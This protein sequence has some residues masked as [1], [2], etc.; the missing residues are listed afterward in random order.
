MRMAQITV[1]YR[2]A[3]TQAIGLSSEQLEVATVSE[4]L[5]HIKSTQGKIVYKQAKAM[6][7]VVNGVS[8]L[9]KRV[10]ATALF[11]GDVVSFLPLAAGG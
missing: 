2:G 7:I 8:I 4:V 3:L 9:Q 11:D 10:Y 1:N 5:R 6:V